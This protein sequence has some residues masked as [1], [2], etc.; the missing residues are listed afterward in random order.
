M[1][2]AFHFPFL[3]L[4]ASTIVRFSGSDF[5]RASGGLG[6]GMSEAEDLRVRFR[7]TQ[8]DALI[9]ATRDEA[10]ADRLEIVLGTSKAKK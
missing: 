6:A 9:V 1:L 10:S 8:Q 4:A 5:L 2:F 7:T 3:P